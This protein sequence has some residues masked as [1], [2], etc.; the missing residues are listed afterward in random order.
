MATNRAANES[1]PWSTALT[2]IGNCH[3]SWGRQHQRCFHKSFLRHHH[4]CNCYKQVINTCDSRKSAGQQRSHGHLRWFCGG[5]TM[6]D[7]GRENE[8]SH[9]IY[10]W[11]RHMRKSKKKRLMNT[12]H[13]EKYRIAIHVRDLYVSW[14]FVGDKINLTGTFSW[15]RALVMIDFIHVFSFL[16]ITHV[17]FTLR[18]TTYVSGSRIRLHSTGVLQALINDLM[19]R[20]RRARYRMLIYCKGSPI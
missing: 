12:G 15:F 16:C 11:A 9:F 4:V 17:Q 20:K 3:Y 8:M 2:R 6:S 7:G 18:A 1:I 10:D 5:C 19:T 14:A 13:R